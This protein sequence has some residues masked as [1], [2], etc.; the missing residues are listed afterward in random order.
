MLS[1]ILTGNDNIPCVYLEDLESKLSSTDITKPQTCIDSIPLSYLLF[2]DNNLKRCVDYEAKENKWLTVDEV[3]SL[4]CPAFRIYDF[5]GLEEL[6]SLTDLFLDGAVGSGDLTFIGTLTN[7]EILGLSQTDIVDISPLSQLVK[8]KELYLY[9]TDHFY[10][11]EGKNKIT[12]LSPLANLSA[13]ENLSV[14]N[15]LLTNISFLTNSTL[16]SLRSFGIYGNQITDLTPL[17]YIPNLLYL[18]ASKNPI[19]DITPL[20]HLPML[21]GLSLSKIQNIDITP[22]SNLTTLNSLQLE[23]MGLN[24]ISALSPLI[25]LTYLDASENNISDISPLSN[26]VLLQNVD[27]KDNNISD[28]TPLP[29]FTQQFRLSLS[30]NV[31]SDISPLFNIDITKVTFI[32]LYSNPE[33][34]CA[35]IAA[36]K[37]HL[38]PYGDSKVRI[39]E[40]QD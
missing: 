17:K 18:T 29:S 25:N 36:L 2:P 35:S 12:D 16:P 5:T 7:L 1:L 23:N 26:M 15:N 9:N 31:I 14:A 13:L 6:T 10:F 32:Y 38:G 8:L 3:T 24:D 27:L 22:L 37:L 20:T 40:C 4:T 30:S 33:I 21:T 28:L 11:S 39:L 19:T 34:P